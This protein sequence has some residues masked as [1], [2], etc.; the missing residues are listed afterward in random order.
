M[1]YNNSNIWVQGERLYI[2]RS[3]EEW[4][5][6]GKDMGATSYPP[7]RFWIEGNYFCYIDANQRK[8]VIDTEEHRASGRPPYY[9][10]I[11]PERWL[12]YAKPQGDAVVQR[13][14]FHLDTAEG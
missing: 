8:R 14:T 9:I 1:P 7:G 13:R 11:D 6:L 10:A 3:G 4:S 5:F 2:L 12:W